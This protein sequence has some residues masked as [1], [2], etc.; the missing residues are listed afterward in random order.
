MASA[1]DTFERIL[2]SLHQA[3]LDDTHWPAASALIEEACGASCNTLTVGE[4]HGRKVRISFNRSSFGGE[5]REDLG[6]EYFEVHYPVDPGPRRLARRPVGELVRVPDLYTERERRGS[7]AYNEGWGGR[8]RSRNGVT[9]RLDWR[10]GPNVVWSLGDPVAGGGWQSAHLRLV[11]SLMSHVRHF[12][13]VRQALARADALRGALGGLLDNGEVGVLQLDRAGRV[14]AA[15]DT[16]LDVLRRGDGLSDRDGVLRAAL[17]ADDGWLRRLIGRALPVFGNATPPMGGS[18]TVQCPLLLSRLELHVHPV[19]AAVPDFGARRAA[20]LVLV[21]DP[22]TCRRID[23]V[24][25]S[26]LLGLTALEGK[27]SALLAE[28]RSVRE[29]AAAVD[30]RESYVRWLLK[31]VYRKQSLSGQVALVRRVLAAYGLPRC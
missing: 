27:V 10:D 21:A 16:A 11:E 8:R 29:I 9:A 1:S 23:P 24:R 14:L 28:G 3:A 7:R 13:R 6:R 22:E 18:M 31:Q 17:P 19:D 12:V 15:N 30:Y 2:A 26:A 25:V 20:A 5:E 4:R